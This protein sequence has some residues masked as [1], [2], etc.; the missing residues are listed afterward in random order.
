[1]ARKR[2]SRGQ[3]TRYTR[4]RRKRRTYAAARTRRRPRRNPPRRRRRGIARYA[5]RALAPFVPDLKTVGYAALG[6]AA[7]RVVPGYMLR[8]LPGLPAAGAGALAVKAAGATLAG[9][10]GSM[11]LGRQAGSAMALG[12]YVLVA[13]EAFRAYVAPRIGLGAY[14]DDGGMSAYLDQGMSQYLAPGATVPMLTS[15]SDMGNMYDYTEDFDDLSG[16]YTVSRLDPGE[17]F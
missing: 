14:L 13:D 15:G 17:R 8:F 5:P 9:W 11:V 2:N 16:E 4:K 6:G 7:T 1:M 3:Y 10:L 12:G